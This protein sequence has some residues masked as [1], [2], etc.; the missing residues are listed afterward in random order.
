MLPNFLIIGAPRAGTTWIDKNLRD[1]PDVHMAATKEVHF[2]DREYERGL[3]YYRS[4]FDGWKGQ[5]AVGEASPGYLH[6][7]YSRNDIPALIHRHLPDVRLVACL[8]NP[9]D[10]L[11][12]EY[13]YVRAKD[14]RNAGLSFEEKIAQRPE[15]IREGFYDEQLERYLRLFPREQLLVVFYDDLAP[16]PRGFLRRIHEFIGV[17]PLFRSGFE[18]VKVNRSAGHKHNAR[19]KPLWFLSR[20]CTRLRLHGL[21]D[22]VQRLN[23]PPVPVMNPETRRRLLELYQPHN[24]RL[25]QLAGRNLD[26]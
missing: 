2:F 4:F 1:H 13:W 17:D 10:R 16:D 11:Y 5:R 12:S 7:Q 23:S 20:V 14:P 18:S 3:D 26:H 19:S 6:G 25:A 24:A 22:T 9:V 15:F 21:A 8:R